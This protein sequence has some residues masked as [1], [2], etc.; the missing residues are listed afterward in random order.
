MNE[1]DY[2]YPVGRFEHPTSQLTAVQ[3]EEHIAHIAA[4]PQQMRAAVKGLSREQ[5]E[6]PYREGGWNLRQVVHHVPD[7]H[8][9]AYIRFKLGV[10]E[11][12]PTIKPYAEDR[13]A[14]LADVS[15]EPIDVSLQ[16]L[17]SLH[18]RWVTFLQSLSAADF[19][20]KLVHP[21]IGEI[22]IDFLL[23]MYSWHGRHH[24][25]HITSLRRRKGW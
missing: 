25:G 9:N 14:Q 20:R 7:S 23:A 10:T 4:T 12:N 22:D 15:S 5:L 17:E 13:W 18:E 11:E 21:D 1:D 3:R 6:T 19:A 8:M 24:V 16:L 2:R